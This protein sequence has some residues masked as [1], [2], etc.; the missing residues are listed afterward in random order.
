MTVREFSEAAGL[1]ADRYYEEAE[2][3]QPR[4][5][6]PRLLPAC[7]AACAAAVLA[8]VVGVPALQ[9]AAPAAQPPSGTVATAPAGTALPGTAAAFN[10]IAPPEPAAGGLFNL[11]AED[12][13]PMTAAQL[14]DYFGTDLPVAEAVPGLAEQPGTYGLYRRDDGSV[15]YDVNAV[16]FSDGAQSVTVTLGRAFWLPD[17]PFSLE[18]DGLQFADVN[19]R[20]L[21][22]FRWTDADGTAC[23]RA[24]FAQDGTAFALTSAGLPEAAFLA[25][26]TALAAPGDGAPSRTVTGTVDVID[27]YAGCIGLQPADG[28]RGLMVFLTPETDAASFSPGQTVAVTFAGEP[29]TVGTVW[30]E[31]VLGLTF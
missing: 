4:R 26:L 15:Y 19:G 16:T 10:E 9:T 28:G 14:A 21:A 11:A 17:G 18:G 25:C 22:L 8:A 29:A 5:R 13:E 7:A 2:A 3:W 30:P 1:L 6:R 20:Q 23:C 24:E 27:P 12:F 31:Q